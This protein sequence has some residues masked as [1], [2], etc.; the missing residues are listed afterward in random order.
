[1][2]LLPSVISV[3]LFFSL[4]LPYAAE[5]KG[6]A[7][8]TGFGCISCSMLGWRS[9]CWRGR[10]LTTDMALFWLILIAHSRPESWSKMPDNGGNR[11]ERILLA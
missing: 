8:L 11:C 5:G 7:S 9:W 6:R 10:V 1:M 3:T 4:R 2:S